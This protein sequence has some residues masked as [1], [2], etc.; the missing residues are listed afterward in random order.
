MAFTHAIIWIDA[1]LARV[2]HFD[3][4]DA[5]SLVIARGACPQ[6]AWFDT[7]ATTAAAAEEIVVAGP[8]DT[9]VN[10]AGWVQRVS[11]AQR[12]RIFD[13]Q[14]VEPTVADHLLAHAR[15]YFEQ[16]DRPHHLDSAG[17]PA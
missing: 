13:V 12:A 10:F 2:V 4:R 8:D 7:I 1:H 16:V 15:R 6:D 17:T 5:E 3:W 11:P 14:R 9:G